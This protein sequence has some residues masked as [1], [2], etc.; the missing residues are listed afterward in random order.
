MDDI[1]SPISPSGLAD[2]GLVYRAKNT[3]IGA[4]SDQ[5]RRAYQGAWTRFALWCAANGFRDLPAEPAALI[6][7]LQDLI[8]RGK[9]MSTILTARAAV[10]AAHDANGYEDVNPGKHPSTR[11]FMQGAARDASP[12]EQKAAMTR[13][14]LAAI[15]ATAGK[16]RRGRGGMESAEAAERR[17]REDYA[18]AHLLR[19][20]GLRVSELMD[21]RWSDV[22]EQPGGFGLLTLVRA[23]QR[24]YPASSVVALTVGCMKAL[25]AIRPDGAPRSERVVA[26]R[27]RQLVRRLQA[28][29][30]AA[31][32]DGADFGSHSGRI[33][34]A[35]DMQ[36]A[37]APDST[38]AR[39]AGW[40]G[41]QMVSHYTRG[42]TAQEA[43]R[44]MG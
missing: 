33:G 14:H 20:G 6:L 15:R 22:A 1:I 30:T 2:P 26:V 40:R 39:Q 8:D 7:H 44:Y 3:L 35:V 25:A 29:L 27:P 13:E 37:G 21:V 17:G 38:T 18:W 42:E 41:T 19:D 4:K 12:P 10:T 32:Y 43:L 28:A 24:G 36:R 16:P 11:E 31:G 34:L 9:G 5:T 23:K